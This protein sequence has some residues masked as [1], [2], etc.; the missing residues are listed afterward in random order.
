MLPELVSSECCEESLFHASFLAFCSF[1][2]IPWLVDGVLPCLHNIFP[3]HMSAL[4]PNFLFSFKRKIT[5]SRPRLAGPR[6]WKVTGSVCRA[7]DNQKPRWEQEITSPF[8]FCKQAS[9]HR[10]PVLLFLPKAAPHPP[11]LNP[12][13]RSQHSP[14]NLTACRPL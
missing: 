2:E 7:S 5:Q 10:L 12:P 3:L 6:R 14:W 1:M 4:V 13:T 8:C 9:R 11:S